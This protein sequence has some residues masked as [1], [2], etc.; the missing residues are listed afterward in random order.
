MP[1][2]LPLRI[3]IRPLP[4]LG[5]PQCLLGGPQVSAISG[6]CPLVVVVGSP[7][8]G[9]VMVSRFSMRRPPFESAATLLCRAGFPV[10]L[11]ALILG[12]NMP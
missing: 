4:S 5:L 9:F 7:P 11:H 10:V 12:H 6:C 2:A 1:P 8:V 3:G